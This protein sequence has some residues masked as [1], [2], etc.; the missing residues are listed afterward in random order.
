MPFRFANAGGRSALV[1]DDQFFDL[2]TLSGGSISADPMLAL[3]QPDELA[4]WNAELAGATQCEADGVDRLRIDVDAPIAIDDQGGSHRQ[5]KF[6][7]GFDEGVIGR[8]NAVKQC[9]RSR[10]VTAE[11]ALERCAGP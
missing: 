4:R 7:D 6:V 10:V 2:E 9:C 11:E 8:W 3:A 1:A 5:I